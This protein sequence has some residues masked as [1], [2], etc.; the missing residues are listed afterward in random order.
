MLLNATVLDLVRHGEIATPGLLCA[1]ADEPLSENGFAQMQALKQGM[2]WDLIVSSPYERCHTFASD[3]AHHLKIKHIVDDDWR[4][5]Y[6]G[7]WINVQRD[8]IREPDRVCLLQLWSQPL[9]FSALGGEHMTVFVDRVQQAF[10]QLLK[11]HQ[12]KTIHS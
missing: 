2:K 12:G 3:L 1:D 7:K 5:I 8:T 9:E 6:F 11:V 4:E 10:N